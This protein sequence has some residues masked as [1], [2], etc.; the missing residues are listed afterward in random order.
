MKGTARAMAIGAACAFAGSCARAL[1][2]PSDLKSS[3]EPSW[4]GIFDETPEL[5]VLVRPKALRADPVYGR[6]LRRAVEVARERSRV[7][8]ETRSLDAME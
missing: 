5:F 3:I 4:Q 8:A 2:P 1:P 6:L 7:V